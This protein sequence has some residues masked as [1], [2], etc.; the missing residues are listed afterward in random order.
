[1]KPASSSGTRSGL[2]FEQ[3]P[4]HEKDDLSKSEAVRIANTLAMIPEGC[5]SL[6][7]V[8]CGSGHILNRVDLPLAFG[9][10]LVQRGLLRARRPVV[11]SSILALPFGEDSVDVVVCAETLEHLD[12]EQVPVAA[13]ELARVARKWVIVTVPDREN[14][15]FSS[16]LCPQ[17]GMVFH[18]HGHQNSFS[19]NEIKRLFPVAHH[20]DVRSAWR[21]RKFSQTLL[22]VRTSVFGLW[23]YTRHTVCP[24]CGNQHILNDSR[25]PLYLLF[26]ALN[27]LRHPR[28][29]HFRWLLVRAALDKGATRQKGE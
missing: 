12:P 14:L 18:V 20:F 9:T 23:R 10:D 28:K 27:A 22:R 5:T 26:A 16:H 29:N 3:T 21:V 4:I 15:L 8:G 25:K 24:G 17:C 1:M 19:P 13:R 6:L 11:R 7:E 2:I